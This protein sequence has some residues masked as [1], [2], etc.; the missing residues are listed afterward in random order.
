ME[1]LPYLSNTARL[2]FP[3]SPKHPPTLR[4]PAVSEMT[5][6]SAHLSHLSPSPSLCHTSRQP[7]PTQHTH[8][9]THTHTPQLHYHLWHITQLIRSLALITSPCPRKGRRKRVGK[10]LSKRVLGV[11]KNMPTCHTRLSE[12]ETTNGFST[13]EQTLI[14]MLTFFIFFF[15]QR[16]V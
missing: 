3:A 16:I 15:I 9:P 13:A 7:N 12:G 14:A 11:F 6:T 1:S 5:G 2:L 8:R 4:L 10:K